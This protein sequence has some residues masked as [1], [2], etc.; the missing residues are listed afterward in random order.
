MGKDFY[1][2][3]EVLPADYVYTG[4]VRIVTSTRDGVAADQNGVPTQ[5]MT[6]TD[7][8][9]DAAARAKVANAIDGATADDDVVLSILN[10]ADLA[11]M[12]LNGQSFLNLLV[13]PRGLVG[14]LTDAEIVA[15]NGDNRLIAVTV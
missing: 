4:Q 7:I 2:A 15:R 6:L 11:N 1:L 12:A 10:T 8:A 14:S 3:L 5:A 9:V 13:S